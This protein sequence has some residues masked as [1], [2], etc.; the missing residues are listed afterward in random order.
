MHFDKSIQDSHRG[1][2]SL[3]NMALATICRIC[4][5]LKDKAVEG[6]PG[7][8]ISASEKPEANVHNGAGT[9]RW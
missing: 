5:G 6:D 9:A 8:H 3:F 4:H 1:V 7:I 2:V